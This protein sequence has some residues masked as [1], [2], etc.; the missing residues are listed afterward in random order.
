[1]VQTVKQY[2]KKCMAAGHYSYLAMLIYGATQLSSS[3]PKPA[4]LLNGR[5]YRE[6]LP[7]KSLMQNA[8]QQIVRE[9]IVNDKKEV[10]HTTAGQQE[11]YHLYLCRRRSMCKLILSRTNRLQQ[12]S[13]RLPKQQSQDHTLWRPRTVP[14]TK[15]TVD[16]SNQLRKHIHLVK[17][18]TVSFP[19]VM[20]C[21]DKRSRD[22]RDLWRLCDIS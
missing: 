10:L 21:Q 11:T 20:S 14:T 9:Q 8:H 5:I 18:Q 6:L 13:H 3:L 17:Q 7:T 4:K 16:S 19:P 22:L 2:L 1:M 15:G 12:P